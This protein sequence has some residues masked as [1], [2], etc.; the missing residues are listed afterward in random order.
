[1]VLVAAI[2]M[3]SALLVMILERTQTIGILKALG[4]ANASVRGIFLYQAFYLI[5]RGLFWGNIAGI[6]IALVQMQFKLV[7]LPQESYYIS[8]VPVNFNIIHI[9]L[10]NAGTFAVC[11]LMMILPTFIITK[12]TPVKAIRFS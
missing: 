9:L 11:A 12:I 10:L 1:M 2:N 6:A 8:F 3:I 7:T 5:S 4:S